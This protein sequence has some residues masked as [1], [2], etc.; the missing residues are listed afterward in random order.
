MLFAE[1]AKVK[2]QVNNNTSLP[3]CSKM[4]NNGPVMVHS[5]VNI[6]ISLKNDLD[7]GIDTRLNTQSSKL[8]C[9]AILYTV[10]CLSWYFRFRII[11]KYTINSAVGK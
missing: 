1:P 3:N 8:L 4:Q 11:I 6:L 7:S 9:F 10:F 5:A 2:L